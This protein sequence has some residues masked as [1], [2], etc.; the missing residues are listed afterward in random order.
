MRRAMT[1][2]GTLHTRRSLPPSW[3]GRP[4]TIT[5]VI[6]YLTQVVNRAVVNSSMIPGAELQ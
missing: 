2:Y 1:S 3:R 5:R 6:I 4:P